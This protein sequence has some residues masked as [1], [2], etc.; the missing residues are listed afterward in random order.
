M[1]VASRFSRSDILT[2]KAEQNQPSVWSYCSETKSPPN[3]LHVD[4]L[5]KQSAKDFW[6]R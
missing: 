5:T 4:M 3:S 6:T 2:A 1:R